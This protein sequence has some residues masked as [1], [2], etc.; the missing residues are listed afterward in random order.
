MWNDLIDG[1]LNEPVFRFFQNIGL[2]NRILRNFEQKNQPLSLRAKRKKYIGKGVSADRFKWQKRGKIPFYTI[3]VF[4]GFI[5]K[6][7]KDG[8]VFRFV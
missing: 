6:L 8:S 7:A 3:L 1:L 4:R 5:K 2:E